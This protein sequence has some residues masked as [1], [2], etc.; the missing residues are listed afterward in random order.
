MITSSTFAKTFEETRARAILPV[1]LPRA[2]VG[3]YTNVVMVDEAAGHRDLEVIGPQ[4][5]GAALYAQVGSVWADE[6]G[7]LNGHH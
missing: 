4:V 5:D 7:H 3:L 6:A 2:F 1:D